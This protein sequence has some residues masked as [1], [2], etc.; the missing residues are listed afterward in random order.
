LA[1]LA[2]I[3]HSV[4]VPSPLKHRQLVVEVL[5]AGDRDIVNAVMSLSEEPTRL[6][7]CAAAPQPF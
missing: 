7:P 4:P 3:V 6:S 5:V 1:P 2:P